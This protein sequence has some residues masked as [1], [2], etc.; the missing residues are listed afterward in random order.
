AVRDGV[1]IGGLRAGGEVRTPREE[2]LGH[3]GSVRLELLRAERRP[4]AVAEDEMHPCGP[5]ALDALDAVVVEEQ[6]EDV[7][8][9]GGAG[10]LRVVNLVGPRAE[11]GRLG[12]AGDELRLA[13]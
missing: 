9:L 8:R 11:A 1:R 5:P 10:E 2:V 4:V 3:P 12:D 7:A 13:D 6:L